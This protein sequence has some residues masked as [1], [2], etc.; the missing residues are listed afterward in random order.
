MEILRA[1]FVLIGLLV[2]GGLV[3]GYVFYKNLTEVSLRLDRRAE[4]LF[5][6]AIALDKGTRER[7]VSAYRRIYM[8]EEGEEWKVEEP[9]V[10]TIRSADTLITFENTDEFKTK[11]REEKDNIIDHLYLLHKNPIRVAALDSLYRTLLSE[12]KIPV[13]QAI[14]YETQGRKMYSCPD[15]DFYQTAHPLKEYV[16]GINR[17]IVLQAYVRFP[18]GYMLRQI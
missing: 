4:D 9:E 6:T 8:A 1:K 3:S 5:R 11:L 16:I 13:E 17:E 2:V 18:L 15:S 14:V 12:A 7:E 10:V